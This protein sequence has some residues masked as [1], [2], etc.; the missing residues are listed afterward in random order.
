MA[1]E[2]FRREFLKRTALFAGA[3]VIAPSL[4]VSASKPAQLNEKNGSPCLNP[5]VRMKCFMDGHVELTSKQNPG[6]KIVYSG[7]EA[8]VLFTIASCRPIHTH[9]KEVAY[10]NSLS[11]AAG[12]EKIHPILNEL[13]EKGF[14]SYSA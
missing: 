11:Y 13:E 1:S 6:Q 9:L 12:K 10:H 4:V 2:N 5:D 3:M 8:G 14:I 7:F